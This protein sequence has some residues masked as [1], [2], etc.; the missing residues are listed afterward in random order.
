M[1]KQTWGKNE[2]LV[3]FFRNKVSEQG[4]SHEDPLQSLPNWLPDGDE[5]K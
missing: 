5:K 3:F 4:F 2:L 1:F